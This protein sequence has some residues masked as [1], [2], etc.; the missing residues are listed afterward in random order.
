MPIKTTSKKLT[1]TGIDI[2][3]STSHMIFSELIL[4]KNPRSRTEKFEIKKRKILHS[5]EIHLTPFLDKETIDLVELRKLFQL[6]FKNAGLNLSE[7]DTGAAIIT[8]ETSKKQNAEEIVTT[9]ADE[10][11]KFVAATAGP[12][13][14]A[15]LAAYGSGAISKS[16]GSG[17]TIMNV[18]V[19]GGSSNIAICKN[20]RVL[21]TAAIN[22]G[23]RLL[24]FDENSTIT[25][26]EET[27]KLVGKN[28]GLSL[29]IGDIVE[30]DGKKKIAFALAISLI[31]A[32]QGDS[33]SELAQ[34][35]MM[36]DTLENPV[37]FDQITFSGGV[38]EYI[39]GIEEKSYN[40]LGILLAEEIQNQLGDLKAKLTQPQYRI[41]AT[42]IGAGQ[43]SLQ[44][45]GSTTFLS[46]NLRYPIRNLHVIEPYL[47]K[48]RNNTSDVKTAVEQA[49]IRHDLVEGNDHFIL[50]F[51]D[52]VR[53]S[54][55]SLIEFSKGVIDALP[56]TVSKGK[57]I[58]MC[59]DTDVGNSVGNVMRREVGISNDILSIDEVALGEGDFIDI[60]EPII[61]NVIV[62]VV[63]KTL[64][65]DA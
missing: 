40:D 21:E 24:A 16:L 5:G 57:P 54:Y 9:I 51:K 52:A 8:G 59:F 6:D 4:E 64:V 55:S 29:S 41:R 60:G 22:V 18:D 30:E 43:S 11:G 32:M 26:L 13:Y 15:V 47:A 1:S 45:S 63:V 61:E 23:G 44:V 48:R 31:A 46:D 49:L 10:S 17:K 7:I 50:A 62:P 35:L 12:N 14:E 3:S 39:Y 27:G 65:F 2:G 36:T 56:K 25:R 33:H 28:V 42:V 20:G 19:G 58:L 34:Q 37:Q 53:P 38:A